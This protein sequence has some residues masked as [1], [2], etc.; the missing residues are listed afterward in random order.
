MISLQIIVVP[1]LEPCSPN[2]AGTVTN[3]REA[4]AWLSYTYAFVR[5]LRNPLVYAISWEQLA[6]DPRL[7][8]HRYYLKQKSCC[9]SGWVRG[10]DLCGFVA[11]LSCAS[12]T[13][14]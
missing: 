5:M 4:A 12:A 6:S 8:L 7:E 14:P 9:S 13:N 10:Q 3:I 2:C 11:S 1:F